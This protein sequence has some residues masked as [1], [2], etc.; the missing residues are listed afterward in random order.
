MSTTNI[1]KYRTFKYQNV[2]Y[3][4]SNCKNHDA[5]GSSW[6]LA[7]EDYDVLS[8][9]KEELQFKNLKRL[10][11][12]QRELSFQEQKK[13]RKIA[14]SDSSSIVVLVGSSMTLTENNN[15]IE[16][17]PSTITQ[18]STEYIF[19]TPIKEKP[20]VKD[21]TTTLRSRNSTEFDQ[22]F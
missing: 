17:S 16:T 2:F 7:E 13:V 20:E 4:P 6:W 15:M 5:V 1:K 11:N 10:P 22:A 12:R 3:I 14:P 8:H 21:E 9:Q 19:R 18:S